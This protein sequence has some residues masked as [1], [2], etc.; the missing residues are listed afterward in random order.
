MAIYITYE[1]T[2]VEFVIDSNLGALYQ[3]EFLFSVQWCWWW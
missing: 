1:L 2:V 3:K